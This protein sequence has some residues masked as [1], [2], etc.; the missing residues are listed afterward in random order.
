[1]EKAVSRDW[2]KRYIDTIM[3]VFAP[4]ITGVSVVYSTVWSGADTNK[5]SNLRVIGL[6]E[7][8]SPVTGK[9]PARR[10]INPENIPIWW[11]HHEYN[12]TQTSSY[13]SLTDKVWS[14]IITCSVT[15]GIGNTS[16]NTTKLMHQHFLWFYN[17]YLNKSY[18]LLAVYS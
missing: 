4:Q 10:A 12:M 7:G 8:N 5:T 13:R 1:M 15:S 11:R 6:C 17:F 16:L 9:F 14:N 3:S 18:M 2:C